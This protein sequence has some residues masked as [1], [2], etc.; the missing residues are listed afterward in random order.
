MENG[1]KRPQLS[2]SGGVL[3]SSVRVKNADELVDFSTLLLRIRLFCR[4]LVP[5]QAPPFPTGGF[6]VARS[7]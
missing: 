6:L 2:A 1:F 4:S 3:H 7:V 5:Y